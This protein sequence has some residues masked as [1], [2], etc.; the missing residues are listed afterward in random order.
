[1]DGCRETQNHQRS[2]TSGRGSYSQVIRTVNELDRHAFQYSIRLTATEPWHHFVEEIH[3]LCDQTGCRTFQVEPAF[4]TGCGE[5]GQPDMEQ[6]MA[7]AHA[8]LEAI[9][10]AAKAGRHL[11]FSGARLGTITSAFCTAPYQALIVNANGDLVT[12]YEIASDDHRLAEISTIGKIV[13]GQVRID[14]D[15]RLRLLNQLS[16][17]RRGCKDCFCYRSCAGNCYTRVFG[18]GEGGYLMRDV[19]C[20]IN[21]A[22]TEGLLL[23]GIEEA[24][25]HSPGDGVWRSPYQVHSNLAVGF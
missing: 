15:R 17:R 1:M 18:S 5:H 3:F 11:F 6:G 12:C 7:F 23:K 13:A 4:N 14:Q 9:E 16:E 25:K 2:F 19:S 22:I 21:R 8:C 20:E 10:I 24:E